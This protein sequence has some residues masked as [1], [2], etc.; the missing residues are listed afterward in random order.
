MFVPKEIAVH[1]KVRVV[2]SL[3]TAAKNTDFMITGSL[4]TCAE[5]EAEAFIQ[6]NVA[7]AA[8]DL[9]MKVSS[10]CNERIDNACENEKKPE[11]NESQENK[12]KLEKKDSQENKKKLEKKD[13]SENKDTKTRKR[14][15]TADAAAEEKKENNSE[16]VCVTIAPTAVQELVGQSAALQL[17]RA[18][19]S[20]GLGVRARGL[21]TEKTMDVVVFYTALVPNLSHPR[22]SACVVNSDLARKDEPLELTRLKQGSEFCEV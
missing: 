4:D 17:L 11:K 10:L 20:G 8:N 22:L 21:Q 12:K 14:G 15:K 16:K 2:S 6:S 9:A 19:P 18:G 1:L 13:S 5:N 3:P 7:D